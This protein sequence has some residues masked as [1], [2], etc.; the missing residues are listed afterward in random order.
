MKSQTERPPAVIPY[1]SQEARPRQ[2][3][4]T[5]PTERK[6][7][8]NA[9]QQFPSARK[10]L[11][12]DDQSAIRDLLR[13]FLTCEVGGFEII[14]ESASARETLQICT[15]EIPELLIMDLCFEDLAPL[16]LI[17]RLREEAK[18]TRIL[19]FSRWSHPDFTR[20]L[21]GAGVH[22]IIFKRDPLQALHCAI[23]AIVN[24]GMHFSSSAEEAFHSE[25]GS[26]PSLTEREKSA[27]C[28]I[29]EGK[30]T[31]EVASALEISV[32]TAEKYRERIMAKLD[33]HDAVQLTHFAIR[34]GLVAP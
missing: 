14:A 21:I 34:N 25:R 10:I 8:P 18:P 28:L 13:W 19:I 2:E 23:R 17:R 30:S 31:K 11:L 7:F 4:S 12:L 1:P 16:E 3:G 6:E 26:R 20:T 32:K 9:G 27:L 24:G 33:L 22:G 15:T 5:A 29:A